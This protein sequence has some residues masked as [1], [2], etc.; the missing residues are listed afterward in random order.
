LFDEFV[1]P[2]RDFLKGWV[3]SDWSGVWCWRH[4]RRVY[5]RLLTEVF[6]LMS[7]EHCTEGRHKNSSG[8]KENEYNQLVGMVDCFCAA[9]LTLDSQEERE[10]P[11]LILSPSTYKMHG[12]H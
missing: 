2:S 10:D 3:M 5:L 11:F 1:L 12:A 6:R 9:Y 4:C 8:K 7:S